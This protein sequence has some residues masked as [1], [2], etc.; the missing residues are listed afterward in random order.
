ML[1]GMMSYISEQRVSSV[2]IPV[3]KPFHFPFGI[4]EIRCQNGNFALTKKKLEVTFS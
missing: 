2:T 3:L 1:D 4:V